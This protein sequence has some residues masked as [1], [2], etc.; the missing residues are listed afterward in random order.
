[1]LITMISPTKVAI[2]K[3]SKKIGFNLDELVIFKIELS[4]LAPSSANCKVELK[5][6]KS[7]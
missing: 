1:M 3:S 2:D 4:N 5:N 7:F 6:L